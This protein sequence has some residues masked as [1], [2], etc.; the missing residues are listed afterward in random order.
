MRAAMLILRIVLSIVAVVIMPVQ[1]L[2][3]K[4]LALTKAR[5]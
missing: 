2:Y 4:A 5:K 1:W 3:G